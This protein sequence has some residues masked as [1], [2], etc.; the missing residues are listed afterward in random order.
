MNL[1]IGFEAKSLLWAF[2]LAVLLLAHT[3]VA[4]PAVA[5]ESSDPVGSAASFERVNPTKST[6]Q[7]NIINARLLDTL[8]T[9]QVSCPDPS[10]NSL[11]ETGFCFLV[12]NNVDSAWGTCCPT[13][14]YL[15]LNSAEWSTQKCVSNGG[16]QPPLRPLSCGSGGTI[17]GWACVYSSQNPNGV[18][19]PRWSTLLVMGMGLAWIAAWIHG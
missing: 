6:T 2:E 16:S 10:T 18:E 17:S 11:C 14:W 5:R 4:D 7:T 1:H 15:E 13:G 12:Q 3:A 19:R 8:N 9:R